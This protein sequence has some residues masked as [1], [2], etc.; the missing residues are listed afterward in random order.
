MSGTGVNNISFLPAGGPSHDPSGLMSGD[1]G[2]Q[3]ARILRQQQLAQALQQQA[4][5]PIEVYSGGGQPAPISPL[6]ALAK[7]LQGYT[8]YA[9]SKNADKQQGELSKKERQDAIDALQK[10]SKN[11]DTINQAADPFNNMAGLD[12]TSASPVGSTIQGAP[13]TLAQK[14]YML[15][16]LAM[17]AVDNPYLKTALPMTQDQT[18]MDIR[19]IGPEGLAQIGPDGSVKTIV[20]GKEPTPPKLDP[21]E[22]FIAAALAKNPNAS[23]SDLHK[24][25][26]KAGHVED[27]SA[28]GW[29]L[30]TDPTTGT[31]FRI[32]VRTGQTVGL[33][34]QP[35]AAK[36]IAKLGAATGYNLTPEETV[37]VQKAVD[38]GTLDV[39]R[40]NRGNAKVVADT[41]VNNPHANLMNIHAY[42]TQLDNAQLQRTAQQAMRIPG[43]LDTVAASG[44]ALNYSDAQFVGKMQQWKN[45]Q[46]NDPA[47]TRY[48]TQRNDALLSMAGAFRGNNVTD[49]ATQLEEEAAKPTMSPRA[50][51]AWVNAHK[52]VLAPTLDFYRHYAI[53]D[54]HTGQPVNTQNNLTAAPPVAG[55]SSPPV[56][57]LK[58]GHDTTFANG[59]VWRMTGGKAVRVK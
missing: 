49:L 11:P 59:Q 42:A 24:Q 19:A 30:A 8:A 22:Q 12:Q 35:Y 18:K 38:A 21:E 50:I 44:K 20:P 53:T 6:S 36:G 39:Q 37:A 9:M 33:D 10:F 55:Q 34:G 27:S 56:S 16:Q 57:A 28:A 32:N 3:M 31:P 45:G 40:L 13:T 43:M 1:Y 26:A 7:A 14:Q 29:Q 25:W 51:D 58:E 52:D 54:P 2:S 47:F 15:P 17:Q 4:Q 46:L 48:M 5:E 23:I 41:L